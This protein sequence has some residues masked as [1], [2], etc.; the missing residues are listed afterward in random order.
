MNDGLKNGVRRLRPGHSDDPL[1]GLRRRVAE[2][3]EDVAEGR[4]LNERL[5]DV[6]DVL[7][8]VLLPVAQRDDERLNAAL[9]KLDD[10]VGAKAQP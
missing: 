9:Q 2:L 1:D 8:E 10:T 7:V 6:L 4:R 5:S 3:E